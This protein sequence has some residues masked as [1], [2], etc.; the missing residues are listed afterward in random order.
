M[1]SPQQFW[2][3]L[4]NSTAKSAVTRS[5]MPAKDKDTKDKKDNKK[6]NNNDKHCC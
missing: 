2:L 4:R 6:D 1:W 3:S 5:A